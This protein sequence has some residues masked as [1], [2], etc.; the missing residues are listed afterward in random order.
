M[1]TAKLPAYTRARPLAGGVTAYFWE[2]PKWARPP[3]ERHGRTCSLVA[4]ALGTDVAEAIERATR[5]NL[6]LTEWRTG[7]A[8]PETKGTVKWMFA[9]YRQQDRFKSKAHKT[10][11]DYTKLMDA[12]EALPMK[13]GTFGQRL[14]GKVDATV[15]DSLY[16]SFKPRGA[17]QATYAMQVCRLVWSWAKR[18]HKVTGVRDNPF[19]GMGLVSTA[20]KGNRATSRAEYDLYR[21]TAKGL[22]FQSMATAAALCF[23]L[24]QRESDVFGFEDPDGRERPILWS[25]YQPG[26]RIVLRQAKTGNPVEIPLVDPVADGISVILYPELE[27]EL[28][29]TPRRKSGTPY[30]DRIV[31]EERSGKPYTL[32]RMSTVHRKICEEAELPK[33]MTFTGF[34]HGGATEIGESG[35]ADVRPISGH[36]T[37]DTSLIYNKASIAKARLIAVKRREHIARLEAPARTSEVSDAQQ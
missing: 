8:A 11:T 23:E 19:L 6:T 7:L 25:S 16:A 35:E 18:H 10:R 21:K 24:A 29:A 28:E 5:L 4:T 2:L 1:A 33:D 9:W 36:K 13:V 20:K 22:G 34:R 32:R 26:R 12:I 14:A 37:L 27:D 30:A 17:R 31:V 3:A 15:A